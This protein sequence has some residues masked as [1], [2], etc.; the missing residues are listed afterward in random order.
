MYFSEGKGV[1][2]G[3]FSVQCADFIHPAYLSDCSQAF[4]PMAQAQTSELANLCPQE[5][6]TQIPLYP[7]L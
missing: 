5:Q 6:K 7:S 1:L 3:V 2:G 4:T